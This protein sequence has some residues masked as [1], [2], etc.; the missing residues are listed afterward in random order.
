[1]ENS[2]IYLSPWKVTWF[3]NKIVLI[4]VVLSILTQFTVYFLPDFPLRDGMAKEFNVTEENNFPTLYSVLILF[5][6]AVLLGVIAQ[7]KKAEKNSYAIQWKTL[8]LIFIYLS[9]DEGLSLHEHLMEPLRK[10]GFKGFLYNAWVVPFALIIIALAMAFFRFV[11]HLPRSTKYLFIIA[12]FIY[13]LGSLGFE[14]IEGQHKFI[15]GVD[16]FYYQVIVTIEEGL[17]MTGIIIF[18]HALLSYLNRLK[19]R[20]FGIEFF[21]KLD[22]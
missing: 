15:H 8:S 9:L 3:L 1:M 14:L 17:E 22:K 18:I 10:I 16:N 20:S 7:V 19:V 2:K 21:L 11:M 4:L 6:S 5:L 12:G 13:V